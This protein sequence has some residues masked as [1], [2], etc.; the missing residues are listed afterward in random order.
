MDKSKALSYW[1][2]G[3][4]FIRIQVDEGKEDSD[5]LYTFFKVAFDLRDQRFGSP[6]YQRQDDRTFTTTVWE[7]AETFFGHFTSLEFADRLRHHSVDPDGPMESRIQKKIVALDEYFRYGFV[8]THKKAKGDHY[9]FWQLYVEGF[10]NEEVRRIIPSRFFSRTRYNGSNKSLA[11]PGL[12]PLLIG[13][14]REEALQQLRGR[15]STRIS[16]EALDGMTMKLMGRSKGPV[17][18]LDLL[19]ARFYRRWGHPVVVFDNNQP[20]EHDSHYVPMLNTLDTFLEWACNFY[21]RLT[22]SPYTQMGDL[23]DFNA[24]FILL[25]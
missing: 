14:K 4:R 18:D 15:T 21:P 12:S 3:D 22:G 11:V 23:K 24:N 19:Q 8:T 25:A 1:Q 20:L 2:H 5:R 17:T 9:R 13:S 7:L 16:K 10:S 6:A